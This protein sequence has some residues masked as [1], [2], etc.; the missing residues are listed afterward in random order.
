[1]L[2]MPKFDIDWNLAE[3]TKLTVYE[4]VVKNSISDV[5]LLRVDYTKIH[6]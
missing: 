5:V 1:M 4:S 3:N 6:G 2:L